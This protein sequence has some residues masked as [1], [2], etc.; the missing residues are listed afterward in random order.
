MKSQM[1]LIFGDDGS[2]LGMTPNE[3]GKV[4]EALTTSRG[5]EQK[6]SDVSTP[7]GKCHFSPEWDVIFWRSACGGY[8]ALITRYLSA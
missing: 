2:P 7:T 3:W 4:S 1:E 6:W 5:C 8:A